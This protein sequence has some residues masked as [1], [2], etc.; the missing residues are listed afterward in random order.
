M[1]FV[2]RTKPTLEAKK[3]ALP[4]LKESVCKYLEEKNTGYEFVYIGIIGGK[5]F[6]KLRNTLTNST[7]QYCIDKDRFSGTQLEHCVFM[8]EPIHKGSKSFIYTYLDTYSWSKCLAEILFQWLLDVKI[9]L[10]A[11]YNSQRILP[12]IKRDIIA[13]AW[14]PKRVAKW[15]DA[16]VA[17]E[18]L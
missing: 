15:L 9:N 1:D 7:I 11:K 17:L 3:L 8:S 6:I 13:A 5:V 4:Q 2:W 16:G 12:K 14:H 18:D 10:L